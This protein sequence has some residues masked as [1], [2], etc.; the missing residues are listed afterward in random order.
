M[1]DG[2]YFQGVF[3]ELVFGRVTRVVLLLFCALALSNAWGAVAEN[4][5]GRFHKVS[6]GIYRGQRPEEEG[7]KFLAAAGFKTVLNLE[8]DD[9]AVS[10]EYQVAKTVGLRF[11]SKPMSGFWA[12]SDKTVNGA[13]AVLKNPANYP[14]FVHCQHGQDRTGLIVGLHRVE[15]EGWPAQ[16]AYDEMLE[17]GFHR[18]LFLLDHY[19][20]SRTGLDD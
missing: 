2:V 8:D 11:I 18:L 7:I 10:D 19:Y 16:K 15:S 13:L 14:V 17:L 1:F 5:I 9:D 3:M 4:P 6:E 20:H 12:P